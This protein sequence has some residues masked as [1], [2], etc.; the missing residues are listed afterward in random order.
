ME[1]SLTQRSAHHSD[2]HTMY[3]SKT[4]QYTANTL[5]HAV[6]A[7]IVSTGG[8][9]WRA[10]SVGIYDKKVGGW[11]TAPKKGVSDVIACRDGTLCCIE[12]KIGKDKLSPE[13][14]GFLKNIA[15]VGGLTFVAKDFESFKEFWDKSFP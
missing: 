14:E 8:Y 11:R 3:T 2:H 13:Q 12:I 10:S 15:H 4:I 7:Y 6:M 5:T 1:R 9:A